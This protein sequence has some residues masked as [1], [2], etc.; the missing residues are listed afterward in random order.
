M[1]WLDSFL[2]WEGIR[3]DFSQKTARI[4]DQSK[5]ITNSFDQKTLGTF[6]Q[7]RSCDESH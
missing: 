4:S 3:S 1:I 5:T 6:T 7:S 2:N